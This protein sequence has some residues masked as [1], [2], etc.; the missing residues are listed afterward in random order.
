M[1]RVFWLVRTATAAIVLVRFLADRIIRSGDK[2]LRIVLVF[3]VLVAVAGI[4][5]V[6]LF[7]NPSISEPAVDAQVVRYVNQLRGIA[8][9]G[10][11]PVSSTTDWTGRLDHLKAH[12]QMANSI[13]RDV[14]QQLATKSSGCI[15]AKTVGGAIDKEIA[16]AGAATK[17]G[18][19][20][21]LAETK[22]RIKHLTE[23]DAALGWTGWR[24]SREEQI[25]ELVVLA[26]E[27]TTT[28]ADADLAF[29]RLRNDTT[30]LNKV[31]VTCQ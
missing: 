1:V 18:L 26:H 11:G 7:A 31:G 15:L 24:G 17:N 8:A 12:V 6:L 25:D 9:R 10:P 28:T 23:E 20:K 4:A 29:N 2:T 30:D 14:E 27:I 13:A 3:P 21:L 5:A 22:D 19:D 16:P